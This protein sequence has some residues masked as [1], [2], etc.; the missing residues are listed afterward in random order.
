[1]S[2]PNIAVH[3]HGTRDAYLFLRYA[4]LGR[5]GGASTAF[6]DFVHVSA[7]DMRT[8]GLDLILADFQE[9]SSR[10]PKH[11]SV[12]S[13]FTPE[14]KKASK[15]LRAYDEVSVWLASESVLSLGPVC[16]TGRTRESGVV[17]KEDVQLISLPCS[18]EGFFQK[19]LGAFEKCCYVANL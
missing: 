14:A 18:N 15:F 13:G 8:K 3:K 7:T 12:V 4:S 19:L 5:E 17:N 1:M 16:V 11:G 2:S 10:D 6:G 9:Y